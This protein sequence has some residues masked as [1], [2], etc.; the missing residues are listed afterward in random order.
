MSQAWTLKGKARLIWLPALAYQ[1]E[2]PALSLNQQGQPS[3]HL[4]MDAQPHTQPVSVSIL[5]PNDTC[6]SKALATEWENTNVG[7]LGCSVLSS[8]H[9]CF[10]HLHRKMT[11]PLVCFDPREILELFP[12]VIPVSLREPRQ[13]EWIFTTEA[14]TVMGGLSYP[15]GPPPSSVLFFSR[16]LF[17]H[18]HITES[19]PLWDPL[20]HPWVRV[21]RAAVWGAQAGKEKYFCAAAAENDLWSGMCPTGEPVSHILQ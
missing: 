17:W 6:N 19:P 1:P 7:V 11:S 16:T 4:Q 15:T 2:R 20:Y 5:P 10:S 18:C 12:G 14:V 8:W 13:H 21:P 3:T 9:F